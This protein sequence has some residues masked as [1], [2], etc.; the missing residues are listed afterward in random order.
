M[1]VN[2]RIR[3]ALR[4]LVAIAQEKSHIN[5]T[6]LGVRMQVSPKYLRKLAGSLEKAGIIK[7]V[8]GVYGGYSLNQGPGKITVGTIM[9]ALGEKLSIT[10]CLDGKDCSLSDECLTRPVWV[11]LET[12]LK[13]RF[14]AIT[15]K[16]I[17]ENRLK[18]GGNARQ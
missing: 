10:S 11:A 7:S 2:T 17:L 3:Y 1:K 6:D 14:M 13:K 16:D 4:M 9:N 5:T 15:L 12:I 8:Q 18:N